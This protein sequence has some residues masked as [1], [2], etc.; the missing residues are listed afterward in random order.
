MRF[1]ALV[2][3]ISLIFINMPVN[4]VSANE[5][6]SHPVANVIYNAMLEYAKRDIMRESYLVKKDAVAQYINMSHAD[7]QA[8]V[9]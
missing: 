6:L 3:I 5:N 9:K 1:K 7:F 2:L 4:T 8:L